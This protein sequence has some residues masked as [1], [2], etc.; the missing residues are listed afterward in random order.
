MNVDNIILL[1]LGG[2]KIYRNFHLFLGYHDS[3]RS[4]YLC[5]TRWYFKLA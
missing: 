2:G 1:E 3:I 4:K 5:T